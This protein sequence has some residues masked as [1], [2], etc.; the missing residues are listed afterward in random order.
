MILLLPVLQKWQ[1]FAK[2]LPLLRQRLTAVRLW[3][4][5]RLRRD[6]KLRI[7]R[8]ERHAWRVSGGQIE[9]MVIQTD[10][11]NDEAVAYLQRRLD[12]MGLEVGIRSMVLRV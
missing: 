10:W 3:E 4:N 5:Q 2:K 11:D 1:S 12:R 8:E 9:R 7:E 6:N